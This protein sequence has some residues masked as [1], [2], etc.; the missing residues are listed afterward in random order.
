MVRVGPVPVFVTCGGGLGGFSW[1]G[2]TVAV[3]EYIETELWVIS[4]DRLAH[5]W[6]ALGHISF[7]HRVDIDQ[8]VVPD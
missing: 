4:P 1:A 2:L 5:Y 7:F 8:F 6:K 3:D